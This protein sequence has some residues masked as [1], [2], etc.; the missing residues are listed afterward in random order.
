[1]TNFTIHTK[2]TAPKESLAILETTEKAYGF[3]PNLIGVL[4]ESPAGVKGYGN[5]CFPA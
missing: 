1:M 2:E 4:A 5:V 3:L